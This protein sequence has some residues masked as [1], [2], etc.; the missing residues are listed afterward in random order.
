MDEAS[1]ID[2]NKKLNFYQRD[3]AEQ[4]NHRQTNARDEYACHP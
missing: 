3:L 4:V 1:A 2:H